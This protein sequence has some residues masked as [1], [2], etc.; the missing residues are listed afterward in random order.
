MK[1]GI[2]II[3]KVDRVARPSGKAKRKKQEPAREAISTIKGWVQELHAG[4]TPDPKLA[5]HKLFNDG[6][7]GVT[8][9]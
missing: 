2:R 5:F 8:E 1:S 7:A 3:K 6:L 4:R 9:S